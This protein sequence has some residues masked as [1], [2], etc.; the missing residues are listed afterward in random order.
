MYRF[1]FTELKN[2]KSHIHGFSLI[3]LMVVMAIVG[4]LLTL[5][6]GVAFKNVEQQGRII[7][8]EKVQQLFRRLS[9]QAYY[10]GYK[11]DVSL[12]DNRFIVFSNDK[13]HVVQFEHISF[14]TL[15]YQIN[16]KAFIEPGYYEV[17]WNGQY[18]EYF[19]KPM[20]KLYEE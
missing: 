11:V 16:T 13:T 8:L 5:T 9:Y 2:I 12:T 15:D 14:K 19:I 17:V 18:H 20:F 10:S 4:T 1:K 7:E 3:E 6:G